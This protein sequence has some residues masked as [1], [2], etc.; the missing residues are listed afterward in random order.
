MQ[1][2]LRSIFFIPAHPD[3]QSPSAIAS[4]N[5]SLGIFCTQITYFSSF[6]IYPQDSYFYFPHLYIT[7]LTRYFIFV[8]IFLTF[9]TDLSG[10]LAFLKLLCYLLTPFSVVTISKLKLNLKSQQKGM[11][12]DLAAF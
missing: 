5:S 1:L 3:S 10:Y 6:F 8:D 7:F 9:P 11:H 2:R 12:H 4:T